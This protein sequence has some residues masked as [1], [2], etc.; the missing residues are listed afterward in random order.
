MAPHC[1][2][3]DKRYRENERLRGLPFDC[4]HPQWQQTVIGIEAGN[5]GKARAAF[6]HVKMITAKSMGRTSDGNSTTEFDFPSPALDHAYSLTC[7]HK[8]L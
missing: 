5:P 4:H 1:G 3:G 7:L 6:V 2:S 8:G